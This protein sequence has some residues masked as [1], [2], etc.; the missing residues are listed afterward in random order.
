MKH[1][2]LCFVYIND[3]LNMNNSISAEYSSLAAP[4]IIVRPSTTM[5]PKELMT[6]WYESIPVEAQADAECNKG[7]RVDL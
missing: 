7:F 2:L 5:S 1:L 4:D 3:M 6:R